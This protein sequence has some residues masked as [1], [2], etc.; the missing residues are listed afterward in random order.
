MTGNRRAPLISIRI[1]SNH[2][3]PPLWASFI[4]NYDD[5]A[6]VCQVYDLLVCVP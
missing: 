2:V 4:S 1:L 5:R 6:S 3:G